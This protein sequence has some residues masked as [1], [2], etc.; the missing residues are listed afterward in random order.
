MSDYF[1][2][3]GSNLGDRAEMLSF[4]VA[5]LP[6]VL[7]SSSIYISSPLEM[8]ASADD[9]LNLVVEVEFA[10]DPYQLLRIVQSIEN[11]AGRLRPYRNAPRSLDIDLIYSAGVEIESPDLVLPHPRAR[12]RLFVL[13][14]LAELDPGAASTLAG[15][16]FSLHDFRAGRYAK[17]Y[18][19]Q[20]LK[21]YSGPGEVLSYHRPTA[22]D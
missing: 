12:R 13:V 21:R 19:G 6:G 2:G 14:P 10:G 7:R 11:E 22:A 15:F 18:P 9:F 1:L 5:R 16:D 3:L 17:I 4:G 20:Y 8:E